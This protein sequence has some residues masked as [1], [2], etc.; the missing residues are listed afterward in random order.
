[1]TVQGFPGVFS[2][3]SRDRITNPGRDGY[4]L[5]VVLGSDAQTRAGS[6]EV[7][8][9]QGFCALFRRLRREWLTS[10]SREWQPG[11]TI[12]A[13]ADAMAIA[14][15]EVTRPRSAYGV[16]IF[17]AHYSRGIAKES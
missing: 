3:L 14:G 13:A 9:A 17:F 10:R 5:I 16:W 12:P 1:M 15:T 8:S 11:A 7:V 2:R 4:I 6:R